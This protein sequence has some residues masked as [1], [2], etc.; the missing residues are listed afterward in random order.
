M[1]LQTAFSRAAIKHAVLSINCRSRRANARRRCDWRA[2]IDTMKLSSA[3]SRAFGRL[4]PGRPL[5]IAVAHSSAIFQK[6]CRVRFSSRD[7]AQGA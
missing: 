5:Q 7:C 3:L 2:R 1:H 4:P 6:N